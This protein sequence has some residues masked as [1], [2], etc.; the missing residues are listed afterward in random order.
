MNEF[1]RRLYGMFLA[2]L[3]AR[4]DKE[5]AP[6]DDGRERLFPEHPSPPGRHGHYPWAQ[7]M[8]PLP[9]AAGC[10]A[11][12][13]MPGVPHGWRWLAA[14]QNSLLRWAARLQWRAKAGEV[15]YAELALDYEEFSDEGL[16]APPGQR[17]RGLA[18]SLHDR[19]HVLRRALEDLQPH[20]LAGT[21]VQ[22]K[23]LKR[24]GSLVALGGRPCIGLRARPYFAAR[25]AMKAQLERP[26]LHCVARWQQRLRTPAQ[27][28][29]RKWR[30]YRPTS[31]SPRRAARP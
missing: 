31:R 6:G 1:T 13:S 22:G 16:P 11:I 30:S 7:L 28:R 15:A 29:V 12:R 8:G 17:L 10:P 19:A 23:P 25:G 26:S 18:M 3:V 24:C 2:V 20:V 9:R 5:Q 21:L 14:L 4:L 27:Q